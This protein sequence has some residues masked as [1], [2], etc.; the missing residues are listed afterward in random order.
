M[1]LDPIPGPPRDLLDDR[2]DAPIVDLDGPAAIR[3]DDVMM[4]EVRLACDV[5][6]LAGRQVDS[7]NDP[8]IHEQVQRAE[9]RR[10]PDAR[11]ANPRVGQKGRRREV[12]L[13]AL[14]H[15]RDGSPRLGQALPGL[16]EDPEGAR[17]HAVMIL[18][19]PARASLTARRSAGPD[20]STGP[21]RLRVHARI[22]T[23]MVR[24]AA[25]V[26][27]IS[28]PISED[29]V[30]SRR[31][32]NVP[33]SRRERR[34]AQRASDRQSERQ[35][36]ARGKAT[37]LWQ[38]P[39]SIVTGGAIVIAIAALLLVIRPWAGASQGGSGDLPLG[40]VRPSVTVP[41][42]LADGKALGSPGA[43]VTVDIWAD[44]QCPV[45][46]R[47]AREVE[48][49]LVADFVEKGIVRLVA[50]DFAFLGSAHNPDES[51]MAATAARCAAIQGHYWEYANFLF[52]N[53]DGEN[54]G[55]FRQER[56]LAMA[57]AVGLD[58]TSFEACLNDQSVR[59][60]V[61]QET[62]EG[63]TLGINSTPTLFVNGENMVGLPSYDQLAAAISQAA[64]SATPGPIGSPAGMGPSA[65][66]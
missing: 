32:K 65:S 14:E 25:W 55:A 34:L 26:A 4:V 66:P 49:R 16:I 62:T 22:G 30:L 44:F 33:A 7:L 50:H 51:L 13:A 45:C 42:G 31:S 40:L 27:P 11:L 23:V 58:H 10:P 12:A 21:C 46:G 38:Q 59:R 52:W 1:V 20:G 63:I 18:S 28:I 60:G 6:M 37:P 5:G 9:D 47:L 29:E 56:M 41:A 2:P 43:P 15:R 39:V 48:P 19:L 54:K 24:G 36:A 17:R 35:R 53:Q 64:G 61:Q 3:T 57:D 8:E